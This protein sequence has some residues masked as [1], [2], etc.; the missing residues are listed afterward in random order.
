MI[1][2]SEHDGRDGSPANDGSEPG[3]KWPDN[4]SVLPQ[5]DRRQ[6]LRI[7]EALLFASAV[8]LSDEDLAWHLPDGADVAGLI[9][10]LQSFYTSRGVNL[11]AV[12][13]KWA[14]RTADDL[15][16]LLRHERQEEK[17]LSK[18]A[19]ETLA[20]IAYHQPVTRAE[21]EDIRG[22][23]ASRGTLDILLDLDWIR[24]KGRRRSPGRPVTYGTSEAFLDHF[25]L[26]DTSDLPGMAELKAAGLL[27]DSL[28][29]NIS[30]GISDGAEDEDGDAAGGGADLFGSEDGETEGGAPS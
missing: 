23:S 2:D 13:G 9:G 10:E 27:D 21:I 12:A 26:Q 6:Q 8:P 28:P 4:V 1:S 22:V 20:I 30:L 15:G 19:L 24:I 29:T 18:A 14:F 25:G 5:T 7:I 11:V 17:R 16:F 3:R